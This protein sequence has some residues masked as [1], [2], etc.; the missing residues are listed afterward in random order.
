MLFRKRFPN[1]IIKFAIKNS[2][3][4]ATNSSIISVKMTS[5]F[6]GGWTGG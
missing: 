2:L 5:S 4:Q 1:K 6:L 3:F